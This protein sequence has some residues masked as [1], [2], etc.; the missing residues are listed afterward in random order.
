MKISDPPP[1]VEITICMDIDAY[2]KHNPMLE[3]MLTDDFLDRTRFKNAQIPPYQINPISDTGAQAEKSKI[4]SIFSISI[5][6]MFLF[7]SGLAKS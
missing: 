3:C 7:P 6:L 5:I 1:T 4:F 2:H